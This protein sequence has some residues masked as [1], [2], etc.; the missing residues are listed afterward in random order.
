[1]STLSADD[2]QVVIRYRLGQCE[3]KIGSRTS[4]GMPE[5]P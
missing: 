2:T 1:M 4:D 5:R 3:S